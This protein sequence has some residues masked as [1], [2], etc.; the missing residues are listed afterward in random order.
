SLK[1]KECGIVPQTGDMKDHFLCSDLPV[2]MQFKCKTCNLI[3]PSSCSFS[4]HKRIHSQT[5]PYIC[6]ECS[7]EF[8][9]WATLSTHLQH[10]CFHMSK[11]VRYRCM[12]CKC[13][14]PTAV[15]LEVHL[16]T[17]HVKSVYKCSACPIACFSANTLQDHKV[18]THGQASL[19][20]R[21]YQQCQLCPQQLIPKARLLFHVNEHSKEQSVRLYVYQCSNC[22]FFVQRKIDFATHRASCLQSEKV[23]LATVPSAVNPNKVLATH[24]T[25]IPPGSKQANNFVKI[26]YT[27][28]QSQM[29]LALLPA[30]S[31]KTVKTVML[32]Q[33]HLRTILPKIDVTQQEIKNSLVLVKKFTTTEEKKVQKD[34]S[35]Q[36]EDKCI[37]TSDSKCEAAAEK[38]D[39]LIPAMVSGNIPLSLQNMDSTKPGIVTKSENILNL[40]SIC[41]QE[42]ILFSQGLS[43][44]KFPEFCAKCAKEHAFLKEGGKFLLFPSNHITESQKVDTESTNGR[45]ELTSKTEVTEKTVSTIKNSGI[46]RNANTLNGPASIKK[47]KTSPTVPLE[48][49]KYRCHLC[50]MLI[51]MDSSKIEEHFA[52]KHPSFKLLL[53]SPKVAKLQ[54]NCTSVREPFSVKDHPSYPKVIH[55]KKG[56]PEPNGTNK[57]GANGSEVNDHVSGD[58]DFNKSCMN[59]KFNNTNNEGRNNSRE[60][61]GF[62]ENAYYIK[63][64]RDIP[65]D[66]DLLPAKLKR[67][68]KSLH[69]TS[70]RADK[71]GQAST[72]FNSGQI[73]PAAQEVLASGHKYECSKCHYADSCVESFR[74]HI[75]L[76]HTDQSAFQCME[77]GMCFVV[78]PS[79]EKHLFISHR[80][81]DVEAYLQKNNCCINSGKGEETEDMSQR[82]GGSPALEDFPPDLVENQCR[83]CRKIFDSAFQLNKHFRTHGMAFLLT[84]QRGNKVP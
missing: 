60:S 28:P 11:A 45:I 76:H 80:I 2:D 27:V 24:N 7:Q 39:A 59:E 32:P 44:S 33:P 4:A 21:S 47:L 10:T 43:A 64:E 22:S 19:V 3:L 15:S 30:S 73:V 74:E 70:D 14:F 84:K 46:K 40:C 56:T 62:A 34:S 57:T 6:P 25:V 51:S 71:E 12:Q 9:L 48:S 20:T 75:K 68:K 36:G 17:F 18:K 8:R 13:L 83:V 41:R 63:T 49:N 72:P 82:K 58:C 26:I 50:K 29:Q 66:Y 54:L 38:T 69:K 37:Y 16:L 35:D 61:G 79:L 78:K 23:K 42:M 31:V 81:K 52:S 5:K 53:L 1:C 65:I 67:K 77:C 55:P